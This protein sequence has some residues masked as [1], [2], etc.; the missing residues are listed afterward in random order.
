MPYYSKLNQD[1][2]HIFGV[3]KGPKPTVLGVPEFVSYPSY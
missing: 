1:R 2:Y 3:L